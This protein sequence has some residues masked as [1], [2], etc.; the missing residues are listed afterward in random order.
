[1]STNAPLVSIGLPVH[2]GEK[3]L[4]ETI[5]A[6]LGQTYRNIEVIICDN[7]ST[8][9]TEAICRKYAA[10]DPRIRYFRNQRN[11]GAARNYNLTMEYARGEYFKWAA[12]DDLCMP[13][14][15]ESCVEVLEREPNVVLAYPKTVIIGP[16]GEIIDDRFEDQYNLRDQQP[17][18]RYK[19]FT[20]VPLDCNAVFGVMRLRVLRRTPGIGPYESS[21]RVLLGELALLGEI[22]EIPERLFLRRFHPGV[23]IF[24]CRSKKE[25]AC[26]FDPNASGRFTRLR[27]F[28]EYIKSLNRAPLTMPQRMYCFWFLLLF[29]ARMYL[30][31]ARWYRLLSTV[32]SRSHAGS[33][34]TEFFSSISQPEVRKVS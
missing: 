27:R 14:F 18:H 32:R 7:A 16:R 5:E 6:L 31:P 11:L 2:N 4:A 3:Y 23:S 28:I 9:A 10:Q 21:D 30:D 20:R 29:Y 22:A 8:D 26:W 19:R 15:I 34:R 25:I 12:H 17:H 1:M 13:S 24:A 33:R